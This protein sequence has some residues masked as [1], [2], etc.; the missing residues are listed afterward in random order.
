MKSSNYR[1]F[2]PIKILRIELNGWT[3]RRKKYP[4]HMIRIL[5]RSL[6]YVY[7]DI[8]R[9]RSTMRNLRSN[10]MNR[11][12]HSLKRNFMTFNKRFIGRGDGKILIGISYCEK[13]ILGNWL[14]LFYVLYPWNNAPLIVHSH[15]Q[16]LRDEKLVRI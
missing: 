2:D 12:F 8:M 4:I 15:I 6:T 5:A 9:Y 16:K 13:Y 1:Q 14:S 3:N 11:Y 10:E 7:V